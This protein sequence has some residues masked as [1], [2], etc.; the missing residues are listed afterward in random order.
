MASISNQLLQEVEQSEKAAEEEETEVKTE[1][2]EG[3]KVKTDDEGEE[4]THENPLEKYMKMVLEAR[5][6]QRIQVSCTHICLRPCRTF[7]FV[8]AATEFVTLLLFFSSPSSLQSPSEEAGQM[9]PEEK[10]LSVEKEE[11]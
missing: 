9:S 4:S 11:R 8:T 1:E 10:S 2:K 7:Q 5:E 6:K 3:Q